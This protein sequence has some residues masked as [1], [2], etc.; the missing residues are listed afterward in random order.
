M[1]QTP[2]QARRLRIYLDE[3]DRWQGRPLYQVVLEA[4]HEERLAGATAI[5]GILGFGYKSHG[6]A[7]RRPRADENPPVIVEIV[8]SAENIERF[9]PRLDELIREGFLTL[10]DVQA[11]SYR[12]P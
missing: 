12:A 7:G 9:M 4:A 8:D 10:D 1:T 6:E 11:V 5:K 2:S 3:S